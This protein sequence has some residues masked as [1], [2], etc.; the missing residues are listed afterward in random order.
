MKL[1]NMEKAQNILN[2]YIG[3]K[4]ISSM[5]K[6]EKQ[7][8]QA[9]EYINAPK[10]YEMFYDDN[11]NIFQYY[12]VQTTRYATAQ[13]HTGGRDTRTVQRVVKTS[14]FGPYITINKKKHFLI[15][16]DEMNK[17]KYF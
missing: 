9:S 11:R 12:Y 16:H 3:L 8:K 14:P 15:E 2:M 4:Q 6:L 17:Y 13:I 7:A 10:I 1:S 5:T